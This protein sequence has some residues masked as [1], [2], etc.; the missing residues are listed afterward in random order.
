MIARGATAVSICTLVLGLADCAPISA[1]S[2]GHMIQYVAGTSNAD[3]F[4]KADKGC[5]AHGRVAQAVSFDAAR[6]LA[7][8]CIEPRSSCSNFA[9]TPAAISHSRSIGARNVNSRLG[10]LCYRLGSRGC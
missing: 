1:S 3:A 6:G 9:R 4:H 5:N 10:A 2:K 8:R 7:F